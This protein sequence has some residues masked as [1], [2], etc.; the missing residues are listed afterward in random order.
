MTAPQLSVDAVSEST[1]NNIILNEEFSVKNNI[2]DSG[3]ENSKN[4]LDFSIPRGANTKSNKR[5]INR[6]SEGHKLTEGQQEYFSKSKALDEKDSIIV[7]N[8]LFIF[9]FSTHIYK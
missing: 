8:R 2:S 1:S 6:Y 3:A 9:S 5:N 7:K 4:K